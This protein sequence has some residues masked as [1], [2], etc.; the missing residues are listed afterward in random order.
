MALRLE[1]LEMVKWLSS[2]FPGCQVKD[3]PAMLQAMLTGC[4]KDGFLRFLYEKDSNLHHELAG[5]GHPVEWRSSIMSRAAAC[6]LVWWIHR[7]FPRELHDLDKTLDEA[8]RAADIALAEWLLSRGARW[9]RREGNI[10]LAHFVALKGWLDLVQWLEEQDQVGEADGL[11]VVAAENGH[12]EVVRWVIDRVTR[13]G[14]NVLLNK[15]KAE[16][17]ISIHGAAAL[18]CCQVPS[19]G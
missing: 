2:K 7:H 10:Q 17:G 16:V 19:S 14:S 11:I 3:G 18:G 9:I 4:K 6:D 15:I 12:L 5:V 1:N 13:S 8:V